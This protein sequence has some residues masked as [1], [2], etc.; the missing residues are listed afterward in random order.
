MKSDFNG[1]NKPDILWQNSSGARLIWLM[2][3]TVHTGSGAWAPSRHP[4]TLWVQPIST[5]TARWTF[6]GK[7]APALAPSGS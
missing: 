4:G 3:G 7:I 5:A 1:D 6:S 2:D